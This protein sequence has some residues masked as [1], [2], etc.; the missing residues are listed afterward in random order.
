MIFYQKPLQ[1]KNF[2]KH[3]ESCFDN[4]AQKISLKFRWIS[5]RSLQAFI[6]FLIKN[7]F[8]RK[9]S[10]G[11]VKHCFDNYFFWIVRWVTAKSDKT[12]SS[13]KFSK[14]VSAQQIPLD[15]ESAVLTFPQRKTN[16]NFG[17]Y[18]IGNLKISKT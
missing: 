6:E 10:C 1:S 2:C 18:L 17:I 11:R 13:N 9:F 5:D 15:T 14:Y 12:L 16:N 8:H 3:L 7:N 4:H